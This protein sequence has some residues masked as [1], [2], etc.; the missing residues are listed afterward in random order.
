[1]LFAGETGRLRN[2]LFNKGGNNTYKFRLLAK[3]AGRYNIN[4]F[5]N[6]GTTNSAIYTYQID[7]EAAQEKSITDDGNVMN[8]PFYVDS[9]YLTEGEHTITVTPVSNTGGTWRF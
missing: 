6:S 2:V 3:T 1:M 8:N 7:G 5:V 4:A 9:V